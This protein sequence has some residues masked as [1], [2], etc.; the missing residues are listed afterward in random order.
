MATRIP[1]SL[2]VA[3]PLPTESKLLRDPFFHIE[4]QRHDTMRD[5][6]RLCL[7]QYERRRGKMHES[8]IHEVF[9]ALAFSSMTMPQSAL[10]RLIEP[11]GDD[12]V[13]NASSEDPP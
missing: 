13:S 5:L 9:L 12:G 2:G 8:A 7:L 3:A 4:N 1:D 11:G 6:E 10:R